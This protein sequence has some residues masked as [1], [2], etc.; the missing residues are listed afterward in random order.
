M[1]KRKRLI[2]LILAV[3]MCFGVA[4]AA[5]AS[6]PD[7]LLFPDAEE[8]NGL[9]D[10]VRTRISRDTATSYNKAE[11]EVGERLNL[12]SYEGG[13]FVKGAAVYPVFSG[14]ELYDLFL[15]GTDK[16]RAYFSS[17]SG[18][19]QP[20]NNIFNVTDE[21]ALVFDRY[22][23]YAYDGTEWYLLKT[24]G[25]ALEPK[26]DLDIGASIDTSV[27]EL[28]SLE[29]RYSI[30]EL[31]SMELAVNQPEAAICPADLCLEWLKFMALWLLF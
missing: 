29:Y 20:I 9:A 13:T 15:G 30:G 17:L 22:H 23:C 1:R 10:A 24:Y 11:I 25:M 16:D 6:E 7:L 8:I 4:G 19:A 27:I 31:K 2:S 5:T 18:L 14:G 12:Y 3:V 21:F 28:N 26:D